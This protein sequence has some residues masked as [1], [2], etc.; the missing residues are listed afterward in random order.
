MTTSIEKIPQRTTFVVKDKVLGVIPL[1][2]WCKSHGFKY[3]TIQARAW[4]AG[5]SGNSIGLVVLNPNDEHKEL[6]KKVRPKN[7]AKA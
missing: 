7:G 1:N 4:R 2:Y 5:L 3:N 6:F